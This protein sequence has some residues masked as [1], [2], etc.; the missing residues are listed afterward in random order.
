MT[1]RP[2]A[3]YLLAALIRVVTRK[4]RLNDIQ[5]ITFEQAREIDPDLP[6]YAWRIIAR[7]TPWSIPAPQWQQVRHYVADLVVQMRPRTPDQTRG[8]CTTVA[9]F[10]AWAWTVLGTELSVEAIFT[11]SNVNRYLA[12]ERMRRAS[13]HRRWD[14]SRMLSTIG[15]VLA[16]ADIPRTKPPR[17]KFSGRLFTENEIGDLYGW[18]IS[19]STETRRRNACAILSLSAGAGLTLAE[20]AAARVE[21]VRLDGDLLLADV[22]GSKPRTVPLLVSWQRVLLRAIGDRTEG[23]LFSGYRMDE[24]PPRS[25]Q[26][27]LTENPAPTRPSVRDLRRGWVVAQIEAGTP[28]PV[29]AQLGGFSSEGAIAAY[30]GYA[31]NLPTPV[32]YFEAVARVGSAR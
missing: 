22:V 2:W 28:W 3:Q 9:G 10:V 8:T 30:A 16:G 5:N 14:V 15:R 1:A 24:Y 26:S 20:V 23:L 31:K 25:I 19:L 11:A 13:I 4:H 17:P 29:L 12:T 21:H 32:D 27:F 6:E 7:F 18:A